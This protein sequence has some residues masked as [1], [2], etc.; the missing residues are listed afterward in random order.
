MRSSTSK[1]TK[2]GLLGLWACA[3]ALSLPAAV[4]WAHPNPALQKYTINL[5][6]LPSK[7]RSP[8]AV[9]RL[10]RRYTFGTTNLMRHW[11]KRKGFEKPATLRPAGKGTSPQLTIETTAAVAQ[12]IQSWKNVQSVV[13]QQQPKPQPPARPRPRSHQ[14]YPPLSPGVHVYEGSFVGGVWRPH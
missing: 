12:R 10:T 8:A 4:G 5:R 2:L 3:C 1:I 9:S 13:E 7:G 14:T 11:M 6:P